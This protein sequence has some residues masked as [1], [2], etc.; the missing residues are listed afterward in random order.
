MRRN[1]QNAV[2]I[3]DRRVKN[4]DA[5][6]AVTEGGPCRAAVNRTIDAYVGASIKRVRIL[7]INNERINRNV[8]NLTPIKTR[9]GWDCNVQI[10]GLVNVRS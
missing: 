6:Q 1:A 5:R 3:L 2:R 10:R 7:R 4:S 8:R 9:P